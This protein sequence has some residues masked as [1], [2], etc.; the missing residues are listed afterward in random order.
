MT[1]PT[2]I[3]EMWETKKTGEP[4]GDDFSDW[5]DDDDADGSG[6][7]SDSSDVDIEVGAG[8]ITRDFWL[9]KTGPADGATKKKRERGERKKVE[10][11]KEVKK[12]EKGEMNAEAVLKKLRDIEEKRGRRGIDKKAY[13]EDLKLLLTKAKKEATRLKIMTLLATALFDI[14]LNTGRSM[15]VPLWKECSKMVESIVDT[16]TSNR[17]LQLTEDEEVD[18]NYEELELEDEMKEKEAADKKNGQD[19]KSRPEIVYIR[20]NLFSF[21]SRL[22]AQ[23]T[24]SLQ[25]VDEHDV[26]YVQRLTD[27]PVLVALVEKVSKYYEAIEKKDFLVKVQLIN[28]SHIYYTYKKDLDVFKDSKEEASGYLMT[29]KPLFTPVKSTVYDLVISLLHAEGARSKT[30]ALLSHV[31]HKSIHNRFMEARNLL[32]MSHL[33]DV[34]HNADIESRILYNRTLAQLG[35]CAFRNGHYGA[36]LDCLSELYMYPNRIKELLAQ[37]VTST[38]YHERNLEKEKLERMREYP[39]HMHMNLDMLEAVNLIS[40]MFAEVPNLCKHGKRKVIS[41]SFRKYYDH[42][43]KQAFTG[44]PESTRHLVM[45]ASD[46]LAQGDWEQCFKFICSL[47]MWALMPH[48]EAVKEKLKKQIQASALQIYLLVYG[49]QYCSIDVK[50]LCTMFDMTSRRVHTIVSRM[51]LRHDLLGAW[52][53]PSGCIIMHNEE[54]SRLQQTA[55]G[56]ADKVSQYVEMNERL[57]DLR[58]TYYKSNDYRGNKHDGKHGHQH[59]NRRNY[60]GKPRTNYSRI[61]QMSRTSRY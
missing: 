9:K 23:L 18:E 27:E 15:P 30:I 55:V 11:K 13:I 53:Q 54:L 35:L 34:I 49:P 7:D 2:M 26:S 8:G 31:Y 12:D 22:S 39:Y 36:S 42:H 24:Q 37:G 41:R 59:G 21:I 33:Q 16:L 52:D 45:S 43:K 51:M 44:P 20:G 57:L 46:K 6:S 1:P 60:H 19:E 56:F 38:R 50:Q 17:E 14:S 48:A 3:P 25:E 10:K 4:A 5:S 58:G 32:L 47:R 28:L 61:G 29:A 40:A